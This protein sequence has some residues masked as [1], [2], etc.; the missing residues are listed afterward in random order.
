[1]LDKIFSNS[2]YLFFITFPLYIIGINIAGYPI[3]IPTVILLVLSVV[4]FF[5]NR[6]VK[7]T[8]YPYVCLIIWFFV[9]SIVQ[10]KM[11]DFVFSLIFFVVVTLPLVAVLPDD[12]SNKKLL[13][14]VIIGFYVS[15][16]FSLITFIGNLYGQDIQSIFSLGS[17]KVYSWKIGAEIV[18]AKSSF[19]EPSYFAAY[20]VFVFM[21]IDSNKSNVKNVILHYILISLA[22]IIT[23]ALTGYVLLLLYLLFAYVIKRKLKIKYLKILALILILITFIFIMNPKV[24]NSFNVIFTE[25]IENIVDS[26]DSKISSESIRKESLMVIPNYYY[27]AGFFKS[28]YGEGFTN[29]KDWV[30]EKMHEQFKV[31][32]F[33][34]FMIIPIIFLTSGIIGTLLFIIFYYLFFMNHRVSV[35]VSVVAFLFLFTTGHLIMYFVWGLIFMCRF[36]NYDRG[37]IN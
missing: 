1:M 18:R 30:S 35:A 15:L 6:Y 2:I 13:K 36:C 7:I 26:E 27:D 10:L 14:S 24:R 28:L 25:R 31:N 21:C 3:N 23:F 33:N 32:N 9:S 16:V 11:G 4:I 5:R 37:Y 19:L 8:F 22:I 12:F 34:I 29:V 20:L 17:P